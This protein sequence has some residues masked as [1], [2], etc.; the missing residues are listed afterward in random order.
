[1]RSLYIVHLY[2]F[3]IGLSLSHQI[4]FYIIFTSACTTYYDI[5]PHAVQNVLY[6]AGKLAL[7]L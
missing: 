1:M 3:A 4:M 5:Y 7:N 6:I 2:V